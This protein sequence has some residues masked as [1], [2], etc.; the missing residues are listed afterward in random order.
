MRVEKGLDFERAETVTTP[1][2]EERAKITPTLQVPALIDGELT[3]WDS[4]VIVDYLMST[5]RGGVAPEHMQPLA[6][7]YV[8]ATQ[9]LR[10][11]L[12]LATLQTF[13]VS[14][15]TVSQLQWSGIQHKEM[16]R[17]RPAIGHTWPTETI[18]L[19]P[20][21][22]HSSL[23]HNNAKFSPTRVIRR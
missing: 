15:T 10:D 12:V 22:G 13:G 9:K 17:L 4:A 5:Y 16:G 18:E 3:P 14:T 23:R 21:S 6:T 1:N 8:R 19:A 2:I 11:R 20:W 7:E